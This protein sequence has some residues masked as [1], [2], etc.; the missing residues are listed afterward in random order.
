MYRVQMFFFYLSSE[1]MQCIDVALAERNLVE[2]LMVSDNDR[3]TT[4]VP[5][6][7]FRVMVHAPMEAYSSKMLKE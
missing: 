1:D 4:R 7:C 5:F 2:D 3:K 6:P